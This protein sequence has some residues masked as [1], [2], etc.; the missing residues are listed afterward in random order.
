[1]V[2]WLFQI[3]QVIFINFFNEVKIFLCIV[4]IRIGVEIDGEYLNKY[5][6][7]EGVL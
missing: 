4:A 7:E 1:M 5:T 6:V 3:N 2:E